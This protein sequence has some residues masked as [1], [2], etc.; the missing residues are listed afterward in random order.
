LHELDSAT[1]YVVACRIGVKS[2]WVLR[3]LHDAGFRRLY[4]LEGG[5]LA[6]AAAHP[7]FEFF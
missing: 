1:T 2:Q 3:R 7:N 4:H 5:L 6:Y